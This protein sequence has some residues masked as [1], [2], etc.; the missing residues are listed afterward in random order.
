MFNMIDKSTF[1]PPGDTTSPL[2]SVLDGSF[3]D[4]ARNEWPWGHSNSEVEEAGS[5]IVGHPTLEE[6]ALRQGTLHRSVDIGDLE[7]KAH[8]GTGTGP[9][10]GDL[11]LRRLVGQVDDRAPQL[12]LGVTD[13][14]VGH[15]D[16]LAPCPRPQGRH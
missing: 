5:R 14:A 15:R 8:R 1:D 7:S 3:W 4:F 16:H 12:E 9:R 13:P 10:G 2:P 6:G 11:A